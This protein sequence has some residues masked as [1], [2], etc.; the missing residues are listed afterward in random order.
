M[1]QVIVLIPSCVEHEGYPGN[2]MKVDITDKCQ[3]CGKKRRV[4]IWRGLSYDG[5]RRLSV[6]C[7]QNACGHVDRYETIREGVRA[8]IY[9]QVPHN[10]ITNTGQ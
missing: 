4:K 1:K 6:D 2:T 10:T 8:G 7:W 5:S 3:Q 9:K